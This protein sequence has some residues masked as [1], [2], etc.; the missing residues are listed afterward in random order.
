MLRWTL[1]EPSA[2]LESSFCV[3]H[4]SCKLWSC[5]LSRTLSIGIKLHAVGWKDNTMEKLTLTTLVL[6]LSGI[7]VISCWCLSFQILYLCIVFSQEGKLSPW[8][9][10]TD[11]NRSV[12]HEK[13][14][15]LYWTSCWETEAFLRP[16]FPP[17]TPDVNSCLWP[18]QMYVFVPEFHFD[19]VICYALWGE[20][21]KE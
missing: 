21:V 19:V 11:G 16:G 4:L 13:I 7:I 14:T 1:W 2:V 8:C 6:H 12:G 10:L 20:K 18:Q 17:G 3:P 9:S 5:C 15:W